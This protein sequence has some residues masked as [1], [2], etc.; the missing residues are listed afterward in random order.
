MQVMAIRCAIALTVTS[1]VLAALGVF[2]GIQKP[3]TP[4]DALINQTRE[5]G[6]PTVIELDDLEIGKPRYSVLSL[7]DI[8][9][10]IRE[11]DGKRIR[12]RGYMWPTFEDTGV[13]RF[14]LNG[15]LKRRPVSH[16]LDLSVIPVEY[17]IL[18]TLEKGSSTAFSQQAIAVDGVLKPYPEVNKKQH[19]FGG[20]VMRIEDASVTTVKPRDD[21]Y[22]CVMFWA[23]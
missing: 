19:G 18:V 23:C 12:I 20:F 17:F 11:L 1:V 14:L 21:Y 2:L 8:P 13:T 6:Q 3:N 9:L 22:S 16:T 15:E 5:S 10:S 4:V 7:E